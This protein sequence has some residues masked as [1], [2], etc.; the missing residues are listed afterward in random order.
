MMNRIVN[1]GSVLNTKKLEND[2]K[3]RKK[4][5]KNLQR[6][7]IAPVTSLIKK[8]VNN[9]IVN[10]SRLPEIRSQ[11]DIA[12]EEHEHETEGVKAPKEEI[13]ERPGGV[14]VNPHGN[15]GK[16]NKRGSRPQ[17]PPRVGNSEESVE[18]KKD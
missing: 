18:R 5:M 16:G 17:M 15:S 11:G 14:E 10:G 2:Y 12:K 4:L 1:Q 3:E 9:S 8:Q 13:P 6:N 7:N